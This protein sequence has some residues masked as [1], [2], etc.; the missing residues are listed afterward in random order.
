M[1]ALFEPE[2]A[3]AG[4]W[5][6]PTARPAYPTF[7]LYELVAVKALSQIALIH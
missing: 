2:V 1:K 5:R 7:Y 3:C 6:V 4:G